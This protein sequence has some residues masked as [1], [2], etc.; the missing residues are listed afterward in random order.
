MLSKLS[1]R[2]AGGRRVAPQLLGVYSFE[3]SLSISLALGLLRL[4]GL[5][6]LPSRPEDKGPEN[7]KQDQIL[8]KVEEP[9]C[10]QRPRRQP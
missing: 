5:I 9:D 2:Q 10:M 8:H 6:L 1:C 4:S 3:T 7:Q